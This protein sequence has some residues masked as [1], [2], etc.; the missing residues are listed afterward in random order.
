M[1]KIYFILPFIFSLVLVFF[2]K[3]QETTTSD[4]LNKNVICIQVITPARNLQTGE[5]REFPTPCDVPEGWERVKSCNLI[6]PILHNI[7]ASQLKQELSIKENLG[8]NICRILGTCKTERSNTEVLMKSA[9]VKGISEKQLEVSIF[10]LNYKIDLSNA[11]ILRNNWKNSNLEEISLGDIINVWGYLD[12]QDFTLVHA[13]N[14]R[15]VSLQV[16]VKI[17]KGTIKS[18]DETDNSFV[19]KTEN[20]EEKIVIV[21]KD[22]KI[23]NGTSTGSF[24]DLKEGQNVIVRGILNKEN[25]KIIAKSIIIGFENDPRGFLKE[26]LKIVK[27]EMKEIKEKSHQTSQ[28]LREQLKNQIEEIQKRINQLMEQLRQQKGG[29][30]IEEATTTNQ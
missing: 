23:I 3:A 21:N 30:T 11:K 6:D 19:L 28:Q 9:I 20:N 1:K 2:V 13:K 4:Q 18:I 14:I 22:T 26:G 17:F 27:K 10:N 24:S 15:D 29:K 7:P 16:D 12:N 5:C 25:S 8:L